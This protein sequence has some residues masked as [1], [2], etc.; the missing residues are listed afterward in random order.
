METL[1]ISKYE[2]TFNLLTD[3]NFLQIFPEDAAILCQS[4]DITLVGNNLILS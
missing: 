1:Q 2:T 4:F 3:F